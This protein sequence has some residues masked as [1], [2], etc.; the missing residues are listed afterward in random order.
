MLNNRNI[1][2]SSIEF[3]HEPFENYLKE[4]INFLLHC[5]DQNKVETVDDTRKKMWKYT[6]AK[7]KSSAPKLWSLPRTGG[8]SF[9]K[10]KWR[11]L[12]IAVWR[13]LLNGDP[14]YLC[15]C[16]NDDKTK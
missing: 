6:I 11:H 13:Y 8:S 7:S 5:Y 3:L 4:E 2:L 9:Q 1:D 15:W 16:R 14:P 12:Q 10:L